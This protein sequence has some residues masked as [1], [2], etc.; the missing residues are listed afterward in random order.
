MF[1]NMKNLGQL[2]KAAGQFKEKAAEL[3]AALERR[4]VEADA[5][6]GAVRVAANGKGRILRIDIDQALMAGLAGDDK[7][8]A[9]ELIASAVNAALAKVQEVVAEEMKELAGGMD[10]PPDI[11]GLLGQMNPG[12]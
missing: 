1:G 4:T 11:Q 6:G 12:E 8:V 9:E 2:M 10:L 3:Q 7:T 5:G